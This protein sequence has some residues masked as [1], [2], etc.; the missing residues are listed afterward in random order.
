M[1]RPFMRTLLLAAAFAA[2][3]SFAAAQYITP[4]QSA[5]GAQFG[6][7]I[8]S[9]TALTVPTYASYARICARTAAVDFTTDGTTP[10]ST[11]GTVLASGGCLGLPGTLLSAFRAISATGTL[12]VEY[13]K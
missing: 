5:G 6:L 8:T 11:V 4:Y 7:V 10:T 13:F 1:M 3:A 12:D 9:S 2:P